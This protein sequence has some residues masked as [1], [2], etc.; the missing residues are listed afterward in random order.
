[1]RGKDAISLPFVP[2]RYEVI[3]VGI[4]LIIPILSLLYFGWF[5]DDIFETWRHSR[6][7][8]LLWGAWGWL[9]ALYVIYIRRIADWMLIAFFFKGYSR[10]KEAKKQFKNQ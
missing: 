9:G 6:L 3:M 2:L 10:K 4:L 1:M 8:M 7:I 5:H